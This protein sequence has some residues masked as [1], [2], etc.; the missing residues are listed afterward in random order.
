MTDGMNLAF[1]YAKGRMQRRESVRRGESASEFFYGSEQLKVQ[2]HKIGLFEVNN[3][4]PEGRLERAVDLLF[5]WGL[6]PNRTRGPVL[7]GTKRLLPELN[8]YD[9]I[10][11]TAT[12]ISFSLCIWKSLGLLKPEVVAIQCGIFNY[13]PN[14]LRRAQIRMLL[15]RM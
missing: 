1:L 5:S 14:R 12:G 9:V 8:K 15:N 13:M 10:V 3:G 11:A 2:G 6:L 4:G 7:M